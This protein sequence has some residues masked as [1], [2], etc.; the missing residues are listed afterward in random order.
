V[1]LPDEKGTHNEKDPAEEVC[2]TCRTLCL[3]SA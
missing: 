1:V 3:L 2:V